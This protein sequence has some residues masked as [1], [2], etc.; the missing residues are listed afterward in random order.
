MD[1]NA[2]QGGSTSGLPVVGWRTAH[3]CGSDGGNCV[4]VNSAAVE[5][6][7][8]RDTKRPGGRPLVF[9]ATG[10]RGFLLAAHD[11]RFDR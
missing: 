3:H 9:P 10:W 11:G 1:I 6:V 5:V 8:V 2:R 7:G 4:E